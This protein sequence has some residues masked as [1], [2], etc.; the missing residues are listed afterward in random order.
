M[1]FFLTVIFAV[2]DVDVIFIFIVAKKAHC[3]T[4]ILL[5]FRERLTALRTLQFDFEPLEEAL[6][7]VDVQARCLV[8]ARASLPLLDRK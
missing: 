7:M 8:V 1:P 3:C 2:T 5:R 6:A 4:I